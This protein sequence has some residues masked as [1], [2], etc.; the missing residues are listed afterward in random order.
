M[1]LSYSEPNLRERIALPNTNSPLAHPPAPQSQVP[2]SA[3]LALA[4]LAWHSPS[5]HA[6]LPSRANLQLW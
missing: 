4:L 3:Q 1:Q 6:H 5:A 2:F